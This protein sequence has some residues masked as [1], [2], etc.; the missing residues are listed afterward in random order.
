[1]LHDRRD[2]LWRW[3]EIKMDAF[4]FPYLCTCR[5][6]P[7][8]FL[9]DLLCGIIIHDSTHKKTA[10]SSLLEMMQVFLCVL[11]ESPPAKNAKHFEPGMNY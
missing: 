3:Q 10:S 1:M 7:S 6:Y 11:E 2:P 8:F 9:Y 5:K 4:R